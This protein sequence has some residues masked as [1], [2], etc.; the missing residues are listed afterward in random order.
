MR[1]HRAR[2]APRH[3]PFGPLPGWRKRARWNAVWLSGGEWVTGALA[4]SH[5]TPTSADTGGFHGAC[6]PIPRAGSLAGRAGDASNAA[7]DKR[8]NWAAPCHPFGPGQ[9]YPKAPRVLPALSVLRHGSRWPAYVARMGIPAS[10]AGATTDPGEA[11]SCQSVVKLGPSWVSRCP[12][13][14]GWLRVGTRGAG[15][16]PPTY[17]RSGVSGRDRFALVL[18]AHHVSPPSSTAHELSPG[19]G[20]RPQK[21]TATETGGNSCVQ[22]SIFNHAYWEAICRCK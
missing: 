16:P 17:D 8:R 20:A 9:K 3:A 12:N 7:G 14:E 4:A 19:D 15:R 13:S 18:R 21:R 5:P 6:R 2:T 22:F 10:D 11:G 1:M